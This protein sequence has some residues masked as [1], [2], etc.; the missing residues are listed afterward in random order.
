M[1]TLHFLFLP[2]GPISPPSLS[3][4]PPPAEGKRE[5]KGRKFTSFNLHLLGTRHYLWSSQVPGKGNVMALVGL[6]DKLKVRPLKRLA[7]GSRVRA[8]NPAPW[9]TCVP[10]PS[11]PG[12][13]NSVVWPRHARCHPVQ[14]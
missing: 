6:M 14:A 1:A 8:P 2:P 10:Q 7:H 9:S 11:V 5:D 12:W 4:K 3:K 13:V